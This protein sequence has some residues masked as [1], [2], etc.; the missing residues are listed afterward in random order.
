MT[1]HNS[2][3]L[4]IRIAADES[5]FNALKPDWNALAESANPQSVFYQHEWFDAAW[6]WRKTDGLL[7]I[8][9]VYQQ[10]KLIGLLPTIETCASAYGIR[11]RQLEFLSVPD[12]QA[13]DVLAVPDAEGAVL[14]I[15]F[16]WLA[17]TR[18][19]DRVQLSGLHENARVVK[20][21]TKWVRSRALAGQVTQNQV[22][23]GVSLAGTWADYYARR[24]RRLKKGNNL[25]ANRLKQTWRSVELNAL[26]PRA[27]DPDC[28]RIVD[29][30][31]RIS[32]SSWKRSTGNTFDHAAP[33]RFLDRLSALAAERGW[34]QVWVL[35]FDGKAVASEY[36]LMFGDTV[37]ALRA[38]YD[39]AYEASSP[40]TYMNWK[41]LERLFER[42]RGHYNMGPGRNAYKLRWAE[43]TL[44][45]STLSVYNRTL[46]GRWL[47]LIDLW[48]KP[49]WH[50]IRSWRKARTSEAGDAGKDGD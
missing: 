6:Q 49:R 11:V 50:A 22:S 19:W 20:H 12:T 47:H 25:I 37:S 3:Q 2:A 36:Q 24:S 15:L 42:G 21:W 30:V 27:D 48:L 28:R 40:G 33:R 14:E 18:G 26:C 41:L 34:L 4:S 10:A 44:P 17:S 31:A 5:A 1:A 23:L 13:C 43:V 46:R 29:E 32:A 45:L 9:C 39:E 8:M 16:N 38:D 35:R 7:H